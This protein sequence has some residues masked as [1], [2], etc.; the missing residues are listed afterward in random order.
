MTGLSNFFRAVVVATFACA[1][2]A[3]MA[4]RL[5]QSMTFTMHD[6]CGGGNAASCG[7]VIVGIGTID[8]R[9]PARFRA[10][11]K[12]LATRDNLIL[13]SSGGSLAAGIALGRE[14]RAS[15]MGTRA[16]NTFTEAIPK[17]SISF[18]H[19]IKVLF[20]HGKCLS[21]C[22]YAFLGGVKR[23]V[24]S[25]GVL[26][27][28]QFRTIGPA[29]ERIER[30]AQVTMAS[31][32]LYVQEMGVSTDFLTVASVTAPE[33]MFMLTTAL[34]KLMNVDNSTPRDSGWTVRSTPNGEPMIEIYR[35]ISPG[36]DA[37]VRLVRGGVGVRLFAAVVLRKRFV[38]S[39]R[40]DVHPI[41]E[42][43]NLGLTIDGKRYPG[44]PIGKWTMTDRGDNLAYGAEIELPL[45]A[46]VHLARARAVAIDDDF[47]TA[48]ADVSLSTELSMSGLAN[49]ANLLLRF[50]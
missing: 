9:T 17:S 32:Q 18:D 21:A 28:H 25:D 29:L 43:A 44:I 8:A 5:S 19:D 22:A 24:E 40:L 35:Q 20:D 30:G 27:V 47:G 3:A 12:A 23:S 10:A 11:Y 33:E 42:T 31:L 2:A 7:P 45:S 39:D 41:G 1:S 14:I 49:G 50:K 26:G 48:L 15:A 36:R 34:A 38:R 46:L 37:Y 13:V 4:Q 6:P 16:V